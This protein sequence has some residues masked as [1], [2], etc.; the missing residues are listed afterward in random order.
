MT[1][2]PEWRTH[3]AQPFVVSSAM[4]SFAQ[5]WKCLATRVSSGWSHLDDWNYFTDRSW[6]RHLL[7]LLNHHLLHGLLNLLVHHLLL[8]LLDHHLLWLSLHEN[9]GHHTLILR[10][11]RHGVLCSHS[12]FVHLLIFLSF[13][14]L[15]FFFLKVDSFLFFQTASVFNSSSF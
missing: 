8:R 7:R 2:A 13:L 12:L 10:H 9:V 1:A 14:R 6:M 5:S 3:F 11:H 15:D 4:V